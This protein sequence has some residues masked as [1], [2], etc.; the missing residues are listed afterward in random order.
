M[1]K[2]L[3]YTFL[4]LASWGAVIYCFTVVAPWTTAVPVSQ[5]DASQQASANEK[6]RS[7]IV[8]HGNVKEWSRGTIGMNPSGFWTYASILG[9]CAVSAIF[10]AAK[11]VRYYKSERSVEG[12]GIADGASF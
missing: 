8:A 11:S 10:C 2:S 9:A 1:K 3:H 5:L 6:W 12:G 4:A 7:A